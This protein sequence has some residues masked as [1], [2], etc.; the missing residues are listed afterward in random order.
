MRG[1]SH[2]FHRCK[3]FDSDVLLFQ[4]VAHLN[5]RIQKMLAKFLLM[6]F[7]HLVTFW[8][9]RR[10]NVSFSPDFQ[11][12]YLFECRSKQILECTLQ[13]W[14]IHGGSYASLLIMRVTWTL[15][16]RM[17]YSYCARL[18]SFR[19]HQWLSTRTKCAIECAKPPQRNERACSPFAN[20]SIK[21]VIIVYPVSSRTRGHG[22]SLLNKSLVL[23]AWMTSFSAEQN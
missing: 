13:D 8:C 14:P 9:F 12:K 10:A 19:F 1:I 18:Q 7:S 20:R 17:L 4:F 23:F 21:W 22:P 15:I 11:H 16:R 6:F 3:Y 2:V 5:Y